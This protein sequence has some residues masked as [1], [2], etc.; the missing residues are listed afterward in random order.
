M[1]IENY[2]LDLEKLQKLEDKEERQQIHSYYKDM[3]YSVQEGRKEMYISI[4]NTLI[5]GG[6]LVDYRDEKLTDILNGN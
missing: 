5:K 2:Y 1:K 6:Y 4:M 3:L